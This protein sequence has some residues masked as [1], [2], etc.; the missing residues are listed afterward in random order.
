MKNIITSLLFLLG[1]FSL[2]AQSGPAGG[3]MP[4]G[5]KMPA[6]GR[7][8]G[9]VLDKTTKEAIPYV[10]VVISK[11]DSV[12]G[13]S[14]TK[15]NGEF[16]IEA[17]PFGKFNLKVTFLG[18]TTLQKPFTITPQT[19]EQDLGNIS[20]E[21]SEKVLGT[22]EI[23]GVKSTS[24]MN[25]DRKVFNVDNNITSKGGTAM[26]VMKNIPSV[27]LDE[28]GNAQ[29]R[30]NAATIYIDGRPTTL[31]LD[32]IPSDQIDR[33]EV[34]TNPS[35][36]FEASTTGGIINI[37]MKSNTK[38]GY[39]GVITGGIGTNNRY[40]GMVALNIKQRPFGL[41]IMYNYMTFSNPVTGYTNR[42]LLSNGVPT[43]YLNTNDSTRFGNTFQTGLI[44]LD[45]YLNNRNT[46][47]LAE[48][49]VSG[50]FLSDDRQHFSAL[51]GS[52]TLISKGLRTA[53]THTQF[54]NYTSKLQYKKTFPKKG[55]EL[56]ADLNYNTTIAKSP[57]T[58]ITNA[59][60]ANGSVIQGYPTT[61]VNYGN[62]LSE[63]YTFQADYTNPI[64][65]STKIE[66]GVRSS[67]RPANQ[68]LDVQTL[69]T[70]T[71]SYATDTFLTAHYR[72]RDVVNAAYVNYTTRWKRLDFMLGLRV[73]D[74]YYQGVLTDK[75]TSFQY[76]YPSDWNNVM[77]ALFPSLFIS[78]K[79]ND[80]QEFQFN[81]SRKINRP[82]YRQLMPFIM[83]SDKNNY[84]IGNPSLTPEFITLAEMN[85][86]QRLDKGNLFFTIFYRNTQNPLTP[87]SYVSPTDG[88]VLIT[89]TIN[90][91]Q[92]NTVGMDNTF[93]YELFKGFEATLNM[94]LFYTVI[95]ASYN[96][97]SISN[98]GFNYTGK[99]NLMYHLPWSLTAQVSG[100]YESPK[101]IPQGTTNAIY[102]ADCGLSKDYHK[103]LVFT[104]SLSDIF[105]TK[106]RGS[107]LVTDMYTQDMLMRRETRYLKFTA[108]LRFGKADASLFKRKSGQ[109]QQ[110]DD[111]GFF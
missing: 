103:F 82:N 36:K 83:F 109:Q 50:D 70:A 64:S 54:Q 20:L 77:N 46:I 67:Y 61:Q 8:Y 73:E 23:E 63:M 39:N 81:V 62:N 105:D 111:G 97:T 101:V 11:G 66:L 92:S 4:K 80:R 93:K 10:S 91:K 76:Q 17:L 87:Y 49:L 38:P 31:T 79:L 7:V 57:S 84:L 3:G 55:Q 52:D 106:S 28:N 99:L 74:S 40:N 5:F 86:N 24:V 71:N 68:G 98:Q 47:T 25:I 18:Y 65:D 2:S 89:T 34:I 16:N 45:Y 48:N 14:F 75:S 95:D 22:V 12:I 100:N 35:A 37:V 58:Y 43:G 26:D 107:H 9:K 78:R 15:D 59:Y 96:N 53:N 85:F 1:A 33:V 21:S 104:L 19:V 13:G 29:L 60:L 56:T 32:Q 102:F 6:V 42:T 90:G 110:T 108:M 69:N 30:Q 94:N 44:S 51:N 88:S 41:S 72:I 27:T